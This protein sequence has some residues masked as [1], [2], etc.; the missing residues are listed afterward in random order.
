M[1]SKDKTNEKESSDHDHRGS[2]EYF[3][4][5]THMVYTCK[6]KIHVKT[7]VWR[8]RRILATFTHDVTAKFETQRLLLLL[9][10]RVPG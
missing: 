9:L 7:V 2:E 8:T 4:R 10:L 6:I 5:S 1:R 3:R